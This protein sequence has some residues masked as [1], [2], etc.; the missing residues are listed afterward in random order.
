VDDREIVGIIGPNGA[1]K[2]TALNL[3]SGITPV[4][5]GEVVL[6][7]IHLENMTMHQVAHSGVSRT[8]QNIRLFDSMTSIQN[9]MVSMQAMNATIRGN[10]QAI[11]N[12]RAVMDEFQWSQDYDILP[13]NLPY[14][15]KRR[16]ELIRAMSQKPNI[17]MLDEPAA[18]LN[19]TEINELIGFIRYIRDEYKICIILIEH[20]LEV[21]YSLCNR[22]YVL[23]YGKL[24]AQGETAVVL[25]DPEVIKA[26]I[27]EE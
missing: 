27:G 22:T 19:P 25:K 16:L 14:G 1:G 7:G 24:L 3:I 8:F 4:D 10:A 18:G 9:I 15:L 17:L 26:Y 20:R 2:T 12:A 13:K 23:N 11:K 6:N 21:V 5:S